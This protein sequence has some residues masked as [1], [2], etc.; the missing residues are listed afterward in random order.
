MPNCAHSHLYPRPVL[1]PA[2]VCLC[3]SLACPHDNSGPIQARITKFGPK[4]QDTLGNFL[5]W[6][7]PW[8]SRSNLTLKSKFTPF[9]VCM[10]HNSSPIQAR[11][12]KFGPEVQNTLIKIPR[13]WLTLI[14]QVEFFQISLQIHAGN[15]LSVYIVQALLL[16][17]LTV[18]IT[19]ILQTIMVISIKS[20]GQDLNFGQINLPT[21]STENYTRKRQF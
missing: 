21:L 2:S 7:R 17:L 20:H 11:I 10:H 13:V 6:D 18:T 19:Y 3:E 15:K 4:M 9:W 8:L 14:F 1:L 12:T 16:M 5:W